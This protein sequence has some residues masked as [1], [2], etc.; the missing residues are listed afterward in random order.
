MQRD[1]DGKTKEGRTRR[2]GLKE[3]RG[4]RS[5]P[6]PPGGGQDQLVRDAV[7]L[8]KDPAAYKHDK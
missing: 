2:K 4:K 7:G 6:W 1:R 5:G 3:E 8:Q